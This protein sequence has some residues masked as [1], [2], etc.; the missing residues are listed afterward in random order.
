MHESLDAGSARG[1]NDRV[2]EI[3]RIVIVERLVLVVTSCVFF[4]WAEIK[5]VALR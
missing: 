4:F 5:T 2:F 1:E 3:F